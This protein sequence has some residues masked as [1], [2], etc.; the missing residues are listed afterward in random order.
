MKISFP[1]LKNLELIYPEINLQKTSVLPK[2]IGQQ[3]KEEIII[4]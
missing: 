4:F 3:N 2:L 1:E